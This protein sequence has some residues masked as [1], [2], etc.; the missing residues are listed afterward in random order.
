MDLWDSRVYPTLHLAD[1]MA[2]G[3][4]EFENQIL[5]VLRA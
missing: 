2:R 4:G 5:C 3:N 1:C